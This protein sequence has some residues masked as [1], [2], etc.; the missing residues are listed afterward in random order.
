[1]IVFRIN[2]KSDKLGAMYDRLGV[3]AAPQ[4]PLRD[5]TP[6][7]TWVTGG[8]GGRPLVTG[9]DNAGDRQTDRPEHCVT[10][11]GL[12]PGRAPGS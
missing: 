10:W 6:L 9:G 8:W 2:T 12:A 3:F 7:S 1:M 4:K 11:A 5:H